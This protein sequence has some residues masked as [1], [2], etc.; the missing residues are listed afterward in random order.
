MNLVKYLFLVLTALLIH[1]FMVFPIESGDEEEVA[2][3]V[4]VKFA[5]TETDKTKAMRE[6]SY[7]FLQRKNAEEPWINTKFFSF[8]SE[9]SKVTKDFKSH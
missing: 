5:R 6:K 1:D 4:T 7:G 3:Q 8:N 2:E 9:E